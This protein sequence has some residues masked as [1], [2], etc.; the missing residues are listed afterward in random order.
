[1]K[2][3][4]K[5]L[6]GRKSTLTE[7]PSV[8]EEEFEYDKHVD[9]Y[10]TN[11]IN[12]IVLFTYDSAKLKELAPIL[13]DPLTE[14]YEE[15]EY[16][17]TPVCFETVFR[18]GKIDHTLKS[19]LMEFKKKVNEIPSEYWEYESIENHEYWQSI[20]EHANA[21]LE[22]LGISRRTY[23]DRFTT[24]YDSDGNILHE[25]KLSDS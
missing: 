23:D 11:I 24:I 15:L 3:N 8:D 4:L 17:F 7:K 13:L 16:A 19:E 22:K 18:V 20:R 10:Y 25:Q 5:S 6:F 1:M 14:L 9:F 2:I 12:A 21:L